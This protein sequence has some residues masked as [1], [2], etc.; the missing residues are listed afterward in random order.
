MYSA[1]YVIMLNVPP[2]K[3][4]YGGFIKNASEADWVKVNSTNDQFADSVNSHNSSNLEL[5]ST[6]RYMYWEIKSN[7]KIC[8]SIHITY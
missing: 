2:H 4:F 3:L 1:S 5:K 6:L 7:V 8:N